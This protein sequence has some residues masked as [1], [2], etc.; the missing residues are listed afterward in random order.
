M[1]SRIPACAISARPITRTARCIRLSTS[2]AG[3]P[4]SRA[5]TRP[6]RSSR[7]LRPYLPV[8]CRRTRSVALLANLLSFPVS[9]R[10]PLPNLSPQRKK[11]KSLEALIR[12]LEGLT[13]QQPAVMVFEDAHWIDPTSREL[14]DLTVERVR[15]LPVLLI[16]TFRP[17][18]QPPWVGQPQVTMLA[19]RPKVRCDALL[20]GQFDQLWNVV[21]TAV[22]VDEAWSH[23]MAQTP[24]WR[25][26]AA[27][28]QGSSTL[29]LV[30]APTSR[31]P[32]CKKS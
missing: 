6:R 20:S 18:F 2:S 7:S 24:A 31:H 26:A 21:A 12:Q 22:A 23:A 17:E 4:S 29:S 25:Y 5:T 8:P 30:V 16:V 10:Y 32:L 14:L 13:R 27:A 11:E 28:S 1:P 19:P 3:H 9:E 15:S